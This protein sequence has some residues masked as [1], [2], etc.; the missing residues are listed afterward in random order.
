MVL[1][2][3]VISSQG[4]YASRNEVASLPGGMEQR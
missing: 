3:Q 2:I 1:Q 4:M